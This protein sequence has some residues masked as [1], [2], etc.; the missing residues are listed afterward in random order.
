M[1][2]SALDLNSLGS[3]VGS[4]TGTNKADSNTDPQAAQDRFLTLLV[5]QINSQDPL[6]P[7]DNAQMT[8]Q[9]AQINTV[10]GIQ[11]LNATLK[12][13]A[14]QFGSL[15]SLQGTSLIGR[16]ALLEGNTLSFDG[17][18]GRGALALSGPADQ[19]MVDVMGTNGTLLDSVNLG[20]LPAGQH[21]FSW[22]SAG[23]D[24][25]RVGGFSVRAT[26][27]GQAVTATPLTRTPVASVGFSA[28]AMTL[29]LQD[30]RTLGY[31]QIK[32]FM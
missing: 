12:G 10:S 22:D 18:Q 29:Q 6:N 5:A 31:D 19:V 1:Y 9:M 23:L 11:Q 28:G 20:A 21:P 26:Q 25:A 2:T 4:T 27:G 14:D 3:A 16:Q 17:E 24:P 13:M 7:M 8:T 30:G 15:Q 32:A